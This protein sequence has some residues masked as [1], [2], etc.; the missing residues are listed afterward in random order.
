MA[1]PASTSANKSAATPSLI[2]ASL[3]MM[4]ARRPRTPASRNIAMT[5]IGSVAAISAPKASAGAERPGEPL[6]E[7]EGDDGGAEGDTDERNRYDRRQFAAQL[8][9]IQVER[10]LEQQRRQDQV[11]Y[12]VVGQLQPDINARKGEAEAGED[13]A[14][15]I[16]QPQAPCENRHDHRQAEQ[17]DSA[18]DKEFHGVPH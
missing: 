11:E 18:P 5:A 9:P 7:P 16:G 2:S 14:D 15:G 12:D 6:D 13:E 10:R 4:R 3:S 17:R 1:I 8:T